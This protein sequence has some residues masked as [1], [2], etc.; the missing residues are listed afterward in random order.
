MGE[1]ERQTDRQR[2]KREK[3]EGGGKKREKM[4]ARREICLGLASLK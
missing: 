2:E 1:R 3:A 4:V